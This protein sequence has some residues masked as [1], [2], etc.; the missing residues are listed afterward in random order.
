M[1]TVPLAGRDEGATGDEERARVCGE[2]TL[3]IRRFAR[4]D[5]HVLSA[6]GLPAGNAKGTDVPDAYVRAIHP[7][8]RRWPGDGL[9]TAAQT[10]AGPTA[11]RIDSHAPKWFET[12]SL[13]VACDRDPA[14]V[15]Q[16]ASGDDGS[17]GPDARDAAGACTV[18]AWD[19][20]AEGDDDL[21]GFVTLPHAALLAPPR[22]HWWP[23]LAPPA[24]GARSGHQ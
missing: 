15:A 16:S 7:A 19:Y 22:D 14:R 9:D 11:T 6:V 8:E 23:L 20:D 1:L 3:Q 17:D 5:V 12:L 24:G 21:L 2:L 18:E 10:R 13:A 4:C